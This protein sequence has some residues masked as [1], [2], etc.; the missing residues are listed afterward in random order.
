MY[1]KEIEIYTD[2]H[3]IDLELYLRYKK[4]GSKLHELLE[5]CRKQ[6][7]RITYQKKTVDAE[8][9]MEIYK[10]IINRSREE[11]KEKQRAGIQRAL[12]RCEKGDGSYGRPR[13]KLPPDFEKQIKTRIERK[14]SLLLYCQQIEMK[15][16]TFYKWVKIYKNSWK[17]EEKERI[18]E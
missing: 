12:K 8:W 3:I 18:K 7:I 15:K 2:D 13:V 4:E 10:M 9:M 14:E 16:S 17:K 1:R 11:L 6:N 5:E